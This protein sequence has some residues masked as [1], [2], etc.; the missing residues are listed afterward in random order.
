MPK[1]SQDKYR[2]IQQRH[3][4][5][6]PIVVKTRLGN[7]VIN[8]VKKDSRGREIV[9]VHMNPKVPM[10]DDDA[11][12]R[13]RGGSTHRFVR[14][15]TTK[16]DSEKRAAKN[17]KGARK[18]PTK[19]K[20]TSRSSTSSNATRKAKTTKATASKRPAAKKKAIS[21]RPSSHR[22]SSSTATP[23]RQSR[24][25]SPKKTSKTPK[26]KSMPNQHTT[27]KKP[28]TPAQK[29]ALSRGRIVANE[30]RRAE[31]AAKRASPAPTAP[32]NTAT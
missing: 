31:A 6:R 29:E 11:I 4:D 23:K 5:K 12:V 14:L 7:I 2:N 15:K 9:E 1:L 28:M 25:A 26:V 8:V 21:S 17:S 30:R 20:A 18:A 22:S 27:G 13:T 32:E 16:E 19:K 3:G 24:P 10:A